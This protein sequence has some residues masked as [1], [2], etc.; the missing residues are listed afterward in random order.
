MQSVTLL[1]GSSRRGVKEG[2]QTHLEDNIF[3]AP[4]LPPFFKLALSFIR[5][6]T[7]FSRI[8]VRPEVVSE[9]SVA[10]MLSAT[11]ARRR[12]RAQMIPVRSL[13]AVQW[14]RT[15]S[16]EVEGSALRRWVKM[17]R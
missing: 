16:G 7:I 10:I 12:T 9:Y 13:P 3:S 2:R 4:A 11:P 14:I 8:T 15:G 17:V 5:Y 6:S 1:S